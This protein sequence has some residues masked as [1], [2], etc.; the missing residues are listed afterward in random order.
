M[1]SYFG[2]Y[3]EL[4]APMP[5]PMPQIAYPFQQL[6][7]IVLVSPNFLQPP[8][9][10]FQRFE[11]LLRTIPILHV[12]RMHADLQNQAQRIDQNVPFS[13]IYFLTRIVT[14]R[15]PFSVVLAV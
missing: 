11:D 10:F 1:S 2:D 14:P 12:G 4:D 8:M 9:P 3:L 15:P 7:T 13:A 6:A 5:T